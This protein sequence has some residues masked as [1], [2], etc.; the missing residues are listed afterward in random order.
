MVSSLAPQAS[1]SANS[2]TPARGK[3]HG[4]EL[5]RKEET[6]D[7]K[8]QGVD[9]GGCP[10]RKCFAARESRARSGRRSPRDGPFSPDFGPR[11][12]LFRDSSPTD[13]TQ[14]GSIA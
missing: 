7:V 12:R 6:G 13:P 1:A 10:A 4:Q 3:S 8:G 2:A 5:Y 9:G 14:R 11:G